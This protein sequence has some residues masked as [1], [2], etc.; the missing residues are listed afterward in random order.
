MLLINA[1]AMHVMPETIRQHESF[2]CTCPYFILR[3][4]EICYIQLQPHSGKKT[5]RAVG[6]F[7]TVVAALGV[8]RD[9]RGGRGDRGGSRCNSGGR[10][11]S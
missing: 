7:N 5:D 2:L 3:F 6:V 11:I 9:D 10:N 1:I 4:G 8:G